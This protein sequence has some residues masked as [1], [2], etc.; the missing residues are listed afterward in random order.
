LSRVLKAG[1]VAKLCHCGH[2]DGELD[3]AEPLESIDHRG[4]PPGLDLLLKSLLKALET[5]SV[6]GDRLHVFL[7]NDLLR[8]CGTDDLAEPSEVSR[9]PAGAARIADILP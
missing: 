1:E 8:R 4:A 3:T 5:G 7:K 9:A 2:R 6:F